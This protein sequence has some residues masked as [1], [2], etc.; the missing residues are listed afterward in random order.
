MPDNT[1]TV[2]EAGSLPSYSIFDKTK[3]DEVL[4]EQTGY[5]E[6]PVKDLHTPIGNDPTN[7]MIFDAGSTIN[8]DLD[9][10][11]Q[12]MG[13]YPAT[14]S[15]GVIAPYSAFPQQVWYNASNSA[16]VL[17]NG[18]RNLGYLDVSQR[19]FAKINN[20]I[21][22]GVLYGPELLNNVAW[23]NAGAL[24]FTIK[25]NKSNCT[26]ISGAFAYLTQ[27]ATYSV[28]AGA[29]TSNS[30]S[31]KQYQKVELPITSNIG[32]GPETAM[33]NGFSLFTSSSGQ[34]QFI[35][36][37]T[38]M[39]LSLTANNTDIKRFKIELIDGKVAIA[40]DT[41]FGPN[42]ESI[43]I[44]GTTNIVD[45]NWHHVV[46]NRPSSFTKKEGDLRYG[47]SGC[48]EIWVD[49]QLE[50]RSYEIDEN[51]LLPSPHILFNDIWNAGIRNG[52][53]LID[54]S[55]EY[56]NPKTI[57]TQWVLE[58]IEKTGYSGGIRD[59][60]FRQY[61]ALSP[62]DIK[63]NYIYAIQNTE[64]AQIRKAEVSKAT[65][66]I[67]EPTV[68]VNK[69]NVL[70][71]YWNNL[72]NDKEKALDGLELDETYNVYSYSVTHKNIISPTQTFNLDLNQNIERKYLQNVKTV[73]QDFVFIFIPNGIM[74]STSE[75]PFNTFDTGFSGE[76]E[77]INLYNNERILLEGIGGQW[78]VNNLLFGGVNLAI[79]ERI[80]LTGQHNPNENG[81]W[82]YNGGDKPLTRPTDINASD[83]NY[84]HVYVTDGKYADTTW[85]QTKPVTHIRKSAQEWVQIDNEASLSTLNSYPIHT[86]F[87]TDS[88]GTQRFIDIN[89]DIDIDYDIIAFMNYP[90]ESSEISEN[91]ATQNE[92]SIRD[93]YKTFMQ[94]IMTAVNGGKSLFVS[95]PLLAVDLGIVDKVTYV[96]QLLETSDGQSAAI[97]PFEYQESATNYFDTHRNNKY[98]LVTTVAG[99]TNKPTY[100]MTDFITYSP[101][102]TNSDYHVKYIHRPNG[103]V[104][105]DEFIIPGTTLLPETLNEQLPGYINAQKN[106]KPLA[107]FA[108]SDINIG[109]ALTK[110]SNNT[111]TGSTITANP[112]DDYI[113]TIIANYG[114]GKIFVNCVENG[115]AFSRAD[116]NTGRIQNITVGQNG[117]TASTALWQYS[118]SRINKK[119]LYDFSETTNAIG[120]T[121]PT[122]GGG[123]AVIQAQSHCSNGLI[124][125]QTNKDD[126]KYQSDLYP[127]FTEEFFSTTQIPVLSMTWLGL[128]WLAGE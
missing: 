17:S 124:R 70:K 16:P 100:I 101:E 98:H 76:V 32:V 75:L 55:N 92:S 125:K 116:Y 111:Y 69:K 8:A 115:Y 121:T 95:S 113:S 41:L 52:V 61:Y 53:A 96:D 60:V 123:G 12:W 22:N 118:T 84:A 28:A 44:V 79:G 107:V 19:T 81:V 23:K 7:W 37:N 64:S 63:L 106:I 51:T 74:V 20:G 3:L 34:A 36:A 21:T 13:W 99:L 42:P 117:E 14:D 77:Q 114:S 83:L 126:L 4:L 50:I 71:L 105:D 39:G 2:I 56:N 90:T 62:H 15:Y 31:D 89:N 119:N 6:V 120:Q 43:K 58:E 88:K 24:E 122:N 68:S 87:W 9:L 30:L 46:I 97:S 86:T 11:P 26:L 67:V 128:K 57:T 80:L 110:L 10:T 78:F 29:Q 45:G 47:G 112:Y 38:E 85:V 25:P 94:S 35:T 102:G 48:I 73:C 66:V 49:G 104:A 65:A 5:E 109:T 108:T 1:N 72:L 91:F 54:A 27:I 103:L 40:F 93:A 82:I 33:F 18:P 127:D 59:Y